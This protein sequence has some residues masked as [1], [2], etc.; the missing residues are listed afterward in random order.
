[1]RSE[2]SSSMDELSD[3]FARDFGLR[4]QGKSAP[5]SASK[6]EA[7][8]LREGSYS[9]GSSRSTAR[10][11]RNPTSTNDPF[12]SDSGA[13]ISDDYVF[14]GVLGSS[15][16]SSRG[17]SATSS[18]QTSL[19]V[20]FDGL[21]DSTTKTSSALPVYDKPVY[22]D[23]IFDGAPGPKNSSSSK[24]EGIFSSILSGSG[25]VST[26]PF[27]DLLQNFQKQMPESKGRSDGKS[28]E[29]EEQNISEF[30]EL[31][32]GFSK[33]SQLKDRFNAFAQS[34]TASFGMFFVAFAMFQWLMRG[35]APEARHQKPDASTATPATNKAEAPFIVLESVSTSAYSSSGLFSDP[36][37]NIRRPVSSKAM[38]ST[39]KRIF[40]DSNT[41][42]GASKSV[43]SS[44][45]KI[46]ERYK[47]SSFLDDFQTKSSSYDELGT[48]PPHPS[49]TYV[50]DN[51]MPKVE[52]RKFDDL[53]S[54]TGRNGPNTDT[55]ERNTTRDQA[56]KI[57]RHTETR[58][59]VWLTVSEVPLHTQP[60]NAPPP[61]RQPP[62]LVIK[63]TRFNVDAKTNDNE[64]LQQ[65]THSH[66]YDRSS[67]NR[68]PLDNL[69]DFAMSKSKA[70]AMHNEDIFNS[71]ELN[72]KISAAAAMKDRGEAKFQHGEELMEREY[73][74]IFSRNHEY[75]HQEKNGKKKLDG[76]DLGGTERVE[77][78]DQER[79]QKE[80]EDRE[81]EKRLEKEREQELEKE[82]EKA[83][84]VAER[85]IREAR[86]RAAAEARQK[87]EKAAAEA[88]QR[89]ER[90]AVQRAAAEARERA[91]TLAR[92]RAEKAAAEVREKAAIEAREKASFEA[93][94][95]ATTEAR[96]RAAAEAR[97]RAAAEARERAAAEARER[98]EKAAAE[99]REKVNVARE[100]AAVERAAAEARQRA[101]RA[102]VERA[103]AEA[104]ERTAA[105]AREKA[106]AAAAREEQKEENDLE[107]FFGMSSRATSAPK[108]RSTTSETM[109]EVK[110][111]NRG[112][113]DGSLRT[114]SG[115]SSTVRKASSSANI[116]DDLSSIFGGE[117]E[118]R[119]RAR[120]ERHQRT[121]E[122]AVK[123]L[124]E[125]NERDLQIQKEQAER[126]RI[127]E[128][129]DIEI[130]RWAAGKEGNLR[131]LL[132]SLQY[133]SSH[134]IWLNVLPMLLKK[135]YCIK[136]SKADLLS[137]Y[138][139][140]NS[141]ICFGGDDRFLCFGRFKE[142]GVARRVRKGDARFV[143]A[144]LC[145]VFFLNLF[146]LLFEARD[147]GLSTNL[148]CLVLWPE[149]G[150]QPVSLTDLITGAAVK[151]VYR[152]STLCIHPDKVQQKGAT[153]QQK[154]IAEKVF[155]LL[156][157]PPTTAGKNDTGCGLTVDMA[158]AP[159]QK[160]RGRGHGTEATAG[161]GV[162]D[163][164]TW[165]GQA[166]TQAR[167]TR[168]GAP[169]LA[170]R[171]GRG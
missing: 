132:S 107:S 15:N 90:A 125:K 96:E 154:Y 110:V 3:K 6:T 144:E 40:A 156:K 120:L 67:I 169:A 114:A 97:E 81:E 91:A 74:T 61:S 28:L 33:N 135:H 101:Q 105:V 7:V 112:S 129:L 23:D 50:F 171:E 66:P 103:A 164:A 53:H 94:E 130:K 159:K 111:Q 12:V 155:D 46:D 32:S 37:E 22:D 34:T 30:D 160:M 73:D 99:A 86:E 76:K 168:G 163:G 118:E 14:V 117:S 2:S 41:F 148:R 5:M 165:L 128:T 58:D 43:T 75:A 92:E 170:T 51:I 44:S 85:A 158:E 137:D 31:I 98:D 115:S 138:H 35:E 10:S 89:A 142:G 113:S 127:A 106:A 16:S 119:R 42:D 134:S 48:E 79:L 93:R 153:L 39:S 68:F 25:H 133:V 131:A 104:R 4:P 122:R 166:T 152:K 59:D 145:L 70:Y 63:H 20:I 141:P 116:V 17:R 87:A 149:C 136:S 83:R 77:R 126:H 19:D 54:P 69:E 57:Y 55:H 151:K 38:H 82:R 139:C 95:R 36:L 167:K 146:A 29:K 1:M 64:P 84:Q 45:D 18:S 8:G 121:Q 71:V 161:D 62:L 27:A 78:L 26:P 102:A 88:R 100:R 108:Q 150:W 65:F 143:D 21:A 60:T 56:P 157:K 72:Q 47:E 49:F 9:A 13:G 147:Q 124:A 24:Y 80:R 140:F 109:F 52:V 123:A 162:I 11:G